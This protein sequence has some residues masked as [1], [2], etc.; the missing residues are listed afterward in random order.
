M[1]DFDDAEK[2]KRFRW[3]FDQ[4]IS[5]LLAQ[6]Y[7]GHLAKLAHEHGLRLTVEGYDLPFGDEGI[8][9]AG[10]DEPMSEFWTSKAA[11]ADGF[12]YH[13]GVQMASVAHTTGRAVVGA[14]S[15]TSDEHEKWMMYPAT[16]KALGDLEFCQGI[17][18]FVIHRY[19][20]QPYLDRAPG[21]TMGPWGL[22]Y[23][24]T[25]TWWEMSK[26]W[27]EYLTRCQYLL[28]QG[29]FAADVCY[30][31]PELPNQTYFTPNP[32][33]PTGYKYDEISAQTLIDRMSV[34][35]GKLVLPD[36]MNYRAL[37]LPNTSKMTPALARKIKELVELG[38]TIYGPRPQTSP[39]LQDYPHCDEEVAAISNEVWGSCDGQT[40]FTHAF[41]KGSVHWGDSLTN[42]V[43]AE[44]LPQFI[45]DARLNWIHRSTPDAEIYFL[46][47]TSSNS[48]TAHCEFAQSNL[49]AEIWNPE[50]DEI[51]R[52]GKMIRGASNTEV[53]LDF[54]PG[55]STF[56]VF[57]PTSTA[58]K[59]LAVDETRPLAKVSGP[60]HL[61]FPPKWGAP[62]SVETP[63]LISWTDSPEEGVKHFSGTATY[64]TT[65]TV[66]KEALAKQPAK[67]Y[68][69]LGDVE[70]MARVKVNGKDC[71]IVWRPPYRV[72][73]TEAIRSGKNDLV[74]QVA[75]LWPNRMIGDAALPETNRYTWSSWEPFKPDA[76]LLKSGLL[77]PVRLLAANPIPEVIPARP[78]ERLVD[79]NT[80]AQIYNEV[81]TPFKYGVVLKG[82]STNELVDCPSVFRSGKHWYMMYVAIT[83]KV[84]YQTYLARSDD[85]LHWEKLGR[86]L[87]FT[88]TNDWDAWQADGGVAL[89]DYQWEGTH[90]LEKYKGRYWLSYIGGAKQGYETD[91][92]STGI[93]WSKNPT[94]AAEWNRI[95]DNP[96]VGPKQTDARSFETRTLYKSQIIH[97]PGESLGWPFV[98]YYNG[99]YKNGYE[100]IGMA[101]SS[102]MIHW[103]RY[104]TNSI[105]VNGEAKRNGISGDP[106]IVKIGDVWTMFYFGA[107]WGPKAFDTFA[108]S[109]D[110]AHWTKW[111]GPHLIEPSVPYDHTYAHKPWVVKWKDVVYHFYC[112][113][114]DQG[115]VIA[116]ATSRDLH[117]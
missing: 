3:D 68:L 71:G 37:V 65:F 94:K 36:G 92:L 66:T 117:Q 81:Q 21:A 58:P 69:A 84:G 27:H 41:G 77:G 22:H 55:D 32:P 96:G 40:N 114:G 25:Q 49:L 61:S 80:M 5:E 115:R 7:T 116:V 16:I 87:S 11:W 15:F 112:A 33:L 99:K 45:S 95:P 111:T 42:G 100:Q 48:V 102:D 64:Q 101:V 10:V 104:G 89:E 51:S 6:N 74:V 105:I 113:V 52:P 14:E 26:P 78:V 28:R 31:R 108:C 106:Q 23:E 63:D 20:H 8:Y 86:V 13:K 107:G 76:P 29:K 75:N 57:R 1:R 44:V 34:K 4:T 2:T 50:T 72:N 19:A 67:I 85:L 93:A 54:A 39:S 47:N 88:H 12:V 24:R 35:D 38:A 9:T 79:T 60:W 73:V 103:N 18:R 62:A 53:I 82:G 91:P 46:A 70:V 30:L 98:I 83:N 109:Y 56:V 17:N 59:A 97:D 110:L 43:L 90:E